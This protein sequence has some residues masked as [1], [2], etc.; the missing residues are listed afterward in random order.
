MGHF[1]G[2]TGEIGIE[3][4]E[5]GAAA[6]AS[7]H[8]ND[9]SS[10]GQQEAGDVSDVLLPQT[11]SINDK[12]GNA[13]KAGPEP[14]QTSVRGRARTMPDYRV[15]AVAVVDGNQRGGDW[16]LKPGNRPWK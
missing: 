15:G 11:A 3:S 16:G 14:C 8:S 6:D 9:P 2:H 13:R 12:I 4:K 1:L 5:S 10:A 7:G